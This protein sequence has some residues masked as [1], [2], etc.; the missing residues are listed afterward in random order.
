MTPHSIINRKRFRGTATLEL[1]ITGV[2]LFTI[3][4]GAIEG[5][6]YFFCKNM[7]EGAAREGCRNGIVT[8]ATSTSMNSVIEYQL[9]IASLVAPGTTVTTSGSNYVIGNYT[10]SYYNFNPSTS[11]E[12]QVTSPTS[13]PVGNDLVVQIT[14]VWGTVGNNF[15]PMQLLAATK[16]ITTS[17][18]MRVEG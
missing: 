17:C 9:Q 18:M 8:G 5:G 15:R 2:L 4:F 16:V 10:V 13:V 3:C 1:A 11:T 12:T 6:Y 7:M 14:A